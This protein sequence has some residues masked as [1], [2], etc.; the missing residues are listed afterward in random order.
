MKDAE[1]KVLYVGKAVNLR[2]RLANYFGRE[3]KDRYQIK[4]LME[5]VASIETIKTRSEKEALLLEY[6][7][8]QEHRPKYNIGLKDDKTF[9]R[10]KVTTS[11]AFPAV[12]ATRRVRKDGAE[13]FG[14]Y[15]SAAACRDMVAQIQKYFRIRAC[16]D[17][18]F[19]NRSRPC[20]EF[21]MARCTAP[22]V[23]KVLREDYAGQVRGAVLFLNGHRKELLAELKVRMKEASVGMKFEEAARVRDLIKDIR[24]SIEKQGVMD[25]VE[26]TPHPNPLPIG[27]RGNLSANDVVV[28]GEGVSE[29]YSIIVG[30]V[31]KKKL[32][33]KDIPHFIECVDI[34]N[35][36]GKAACGAIVC[37][38]DG[39]P[40]KPRY[41]LF[42]ITRDETPND[43]A[44][45]HEVLERRFKHKEWGTPD[46]LMVDGG[47][48]Q[49]SIACKV[50]DDLQLNV[51]VCAIAK[52]KSPSP[53]G[54]EACPELVE[55]GRGEGALPVKL[56]LP[57]R[58]NQVKFKKGEPSLLYLIKIRDEAH[59]FAIRQ[60]HRRR[61]L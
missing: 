49:L 35:I 22:C 20:I 19:A 51:P 18:E 50:M 17:R 29:T 12:F 30:A 32:R 60:H 28:E 3:T 7:L 39:S 21:D 44:M 33:L 42:N 2:K 9:L 43:Y 10:V 40:F 54:G 61:K 6:K 13:Y 52:V 25:P 11:H 58:T 36:Q 15:V 23:G 16:S 24:R 48:G 31:L 14:P 8:V 55:G 27:E 26:K 41:R 56:Y 59:R 37:F 5:R 57:N 38:L 45:M 34:S 4:F 46:L 53:R 1:G 47:R